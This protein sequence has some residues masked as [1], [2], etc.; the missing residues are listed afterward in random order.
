MGQSDLLVEI[1]GSLGSNPLG[2]LIGLAVKKVAVEHPE[3]LARL[4][5]DKASLA[6]DIRVW[7][8]K[9]RKHRDQERAFD[10][11]VHTAS[12][13]ILRTR[14]FPPFSGHRLRC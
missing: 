8:V 13:L 2:K 4:G 3:R 6:T 12:A 7:K 11:D 5:C 1:L 9:I 10:V 14:T